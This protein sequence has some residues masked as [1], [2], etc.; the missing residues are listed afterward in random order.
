MDWRFRLA[1]E[2][3]F[4]GLDAV[5]Q[6]MRAWES[7]TLGQLD[8]AVEESANTAVDAAQ[9]AVRVDSGDLQESIESHRVGW[10]H[11]LVTAGQGLGYA[12]R[13]EALDPF[14]TPSV[15]Q[16]RNDLRRRVSGLRR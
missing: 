14:F 12:K 10:G 7:D 13:I 15:K 11:Q 9:S 6:R 4:T 2:F 8:Q 16:A 5:L 3:S 1:A